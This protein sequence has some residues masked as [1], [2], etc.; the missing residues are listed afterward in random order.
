[1]RASF[2]PLLLLASSLRAAEFPSAKLDSLS[3]AAVSQGAETQAAFRE[4]RD[5]DCAEPTAGCLVALLRLAGRFDST[6]VKTARLHAFTGRWVQSGSADGLTEDQRRDVRHRYAVAIKGVVVWV[7]GL[8][9]LLN[10]SPDNNLMKPLFE[11]AELRLQAAVEAYA[12]S[13]MDFAEAASEATKGF[14]V[15]SQAP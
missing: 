7:D 4:T 2:L 15:P 14:P 11:R 5:R 6:R 3:A 13:A 12:K 8:D 9:R 1:M 10:L